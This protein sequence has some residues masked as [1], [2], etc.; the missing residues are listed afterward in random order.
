MLKNRLHAVR[1]TWLC[2]S[3]LAA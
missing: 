3:L 1:R 2:G